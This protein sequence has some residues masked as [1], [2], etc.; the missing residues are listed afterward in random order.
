M[1]IK[2]ISKYDVQNITLEASGGYERNLIKLL[3]QA[4]FTILRPNAMNVKMFAKGCNIKAKTDKVDAKILAMYGC[5]SQHHQLLR[6]TP[7]QEDLKELRA[8]FLE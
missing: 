5:L 8:V 7:L 4:N 2:K 1:T 6:T 3:H